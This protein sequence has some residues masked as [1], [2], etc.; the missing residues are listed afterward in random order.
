[1]P[2][3]LAIQNVGEYYSS[4]YL[5]TTFSKDTKNLKADWKAAGANATPRRLRKLSQRYFRAKAQALEEMNPAQRHEAGPDIA[6]WH[7]YLLQALGY[8]HWQRQDL[9]VEGG[10]AVVPA[11]G[12]LKRFGQPWLVICESLF[13]LPD[14]S[15]PDGAASEDPLEAS[16]RGDQRT[17]SEQPLV[18]GNWTR[19]IGEIFKTEEPPRWVMLLGGSRILLIDRKTF[20][21]GRWLAFDLDAAFGRNETSTFEQIATFL[22]RQTLAPDSESADLIHDKLEEQSHKLAHGVTESLQAAVREAIELLA[23]EWVSDRRRRKRSMTTVS[24]E[25]LALE[26]NG[27]G[28]GPVR[29]TA[30]QL[31]QEAL[32]YVYRLIFVFMRRPTGRRWGFCPSMTTP[33]A[34]AIAWSL[35]GIWSW[36]PCRSRRRRAPIFRPIWIGCLP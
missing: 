32:S 21:N 22:S 15:L 36:C 34:W 25:E 8:D 6:A 35:C 16:P 19:A 27:G 9:F 28:D 24:G 12:V 3:D 20:A 4:H 10:H 29:V 5:D 23:N 18:A 2:L 14:G 17:N 1:M 11:L 31:R 26:A 13:C 30:E 7:A 33:I